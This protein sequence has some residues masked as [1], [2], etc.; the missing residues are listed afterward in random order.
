MHLKYD[1]FLEP[2]LQAATPEVLFQAP[3]LLSKCPVPFTH[4]EIDIHLTIH[5][6]LA[7][8]YIQ[9]RL[10][11]HIFTWTPWRLAAVTQ[12]VCQNVTQAKI[13]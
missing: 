13:Y 6:I 7:Y 2:C 12:P 5:Q 11:G 1:V 3:I 9:R 10:L 8:T 4:H